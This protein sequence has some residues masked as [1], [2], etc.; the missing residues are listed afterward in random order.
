MRIGIDASC[1]A[2]RRGFGRFTRG[3]VHELVRHAGHDYVLLIDELSLVNATLPEGVEVVPVRVELAPARAASAEGSRTLRDLARMAAAARRAACAAFYFPATYS[4]FPVVG[5]PTVVTVHD[6]TTERL[7]HLTFPTRAARWRW[8]VKQRLALRQAC[9][10]VTVSQA[11]RREVIEFL[12]VP[13]RRVHVIREAPDPEFRPLTAA[14]RVA[15]LASHGLVPDA[16]YLLYVGGISPHKNLEVL[17]AAFEE[18]A[19]DHSDLRLLLAGDAS[20]DPFLSSATVVRKVAET[21]PFADRVTFTGFVDDELLVALYGGAVA[22]VLPS[23]GEGFGLTAAESA[24]CGTPVVASELPALR[25]LL[26]SAALYAAPRDVAG[27]ARA[28]RQLLDDPDG[29][30][31]RAAASLRRA[32][33]WSWSAAAAT[34][35]GLIE[36]AGSVRTGSRT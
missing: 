4:W 36:E 15:V 14:R 11:S 9:A 13:E 33:G 20:D 28:F 7:P 19:R 31:G 10:V 34:V 17:L 1:W 22:T 12:G 27:F 32:A 30:A 25:E 2:N 21:S 29:R 8:R 6:A 23:L 24:A 26:G 16:R 35:L 3:L 18:V 5:T